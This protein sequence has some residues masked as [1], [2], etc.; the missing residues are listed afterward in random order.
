MKKSFLILLFI[1]YYMQT[2]ERAIIPNARHNLI[3]LAIGTC[4]GTLFNLQSNNFFM[5]NLGGISFSYLTYLASNYFSEI[6]EN[7]LFNER[8]NFL[9]FNDRDALLLTAFTCSALTTMALKYMR[10]S[11]RTLPTEDPFK[12]KCFCE[13]ACEKLQAGC[14]KIKETREFLKTLPPHKNPEL[15]FIDLNHNKISL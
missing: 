3:T 6:W 14:E 2:M 12:T 1:P 8:E 11:K 7:Q 5:R 13:K 15:N 4:G 10:S 9:H